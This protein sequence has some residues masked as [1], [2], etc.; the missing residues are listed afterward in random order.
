[1]SLRYGALAAVG[2]A[3][4]SLPNLCALGLALTGM[5]A[6]SL[7]IRD[8]LLAALSLVLVALLAGY[9]FRFRVERAAAWQLVQLARP[10]IAAQG[11]DALLE[12][13]DRLA[14]AT[15]FDPRVVGLYHQA[16]QVALSGV[17]AGRP[18]LQLAFNLYARVQDD[19]ERL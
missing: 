11:S 14:L 9:R 12:R 16:R 15:A 8:L 5:D 10:L 2:M 17:Q 1:R 7:V 18:V 13:V 6:W 4:S 19:R 3:S